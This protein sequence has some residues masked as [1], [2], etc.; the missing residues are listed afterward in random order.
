MLNKQ[1]WDELTDGQLNK[2]ANHTMNPHAVK[3]VHFFSH[4][5]G[6]FPFAGVKLSDSVMECSEILIEIFAC[7]RSF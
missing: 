4:D 6:L 5:P 3:K 7:A 2:C 1:L